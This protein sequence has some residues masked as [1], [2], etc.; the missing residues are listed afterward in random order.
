VVDPNV[1]ASGG[2]A[3]GAGRRR[4]SPLARIVVAFVVIVVALLAAAPS[5]V[6]VVGRAWVES[7]AAAALE[8][9][10][11]IGDLAL[12]WWSGIRVRD[13]DV[14]AREPGK[15]TF[16]IASIEAKPDLG[17]LLSGRVSVP[18]LVVKHV[19][20]ELS[21]DP[22]APE[23]D[24]E[25]DEDEGGDDPASVAKRALPD[26]EVNATIEDVT[27]AYRS[28]E[29]ERPVRISGVGPV[30]ISA[31]SR[32]ATRI[33]VAA[34]P[35]VTAKL[36][37]LW[38]RDGKRLRRRDHTLSGD[39]RLEGADLARFRDAA[40]PWIDA[41]AG[42]AEGAIRVQAVGKGVAST[43]TLRIARAALTPAGA[44]AAHVLEDVTVTH[45]VRRDA[46]TRAWTGT[47]DLASAAGTLA[48]ASA[49][50]QPLVLERAI[51]RGRLS[52]DLRIDVDAVEAVADF[53]RIAGSGSFG[54]GKAPAGTS[55]RL[56][57]T[58]DAQQLA[59][60]L[61]G[62]PPLSGAITSSAAVAIGPD[63]LMTI[64]GA[65]K[66]A[67]FVAQDVPGVGTIRERE[68]VLKHDL[69]WG[70]DAI[71]MHDVGLSS[72]FAT[73][74]CSGAIQTRPGGEA[75]E[76]SL[77]LDVSVALDVVAGLLGEHL[78]MKPSG[79]LAV[80]GK[81]VASPV[82]LAVDVDMK[83]DGITLGGGPFAR[84]PFALGD[85]RAAAKGEIS[86]DWSRLDLPEWSL[87]SSVC[88]LSGSL[89]AS[90]IGDDVHAADVAV[91]GSVEPDR[92]LPALMEEP[93]RARLGPVEVAA[94]VAG[95]DAAWNAAIERVTGAGLTVQGSAVLPRGAARAAPSFSVAILGSVD[96]LAKAFVEGH[97]VSGSIRGNLGGSL[98]DGAVLDAQLQ[99]ENLRVVAAG[100]GGAIGGN[101]LLAG[102]TDEARRFD[103]RLSSPKLTF[104]QKDGRTIAGEVDALLQ[105]RFDPDRDAWVVETLRAT[106]P[107]TS[108]SGHGTF[109]AGE[110][111]DVDVAADLEMAGA[112]PLVAF[113]YPDL[114]CSGKGALAAK[115][116]MSLAEP[117][118]PADSN[119]TLTL[120]M[121]GIRS[122]VFDLRN[123]DVD[124]VMEGGV[125][126]T[127]KATATLNG[128]S[129]QLDLSVDLR[130]AVAEWRGSTKLDAVRITKEMQP[131]I[132][133][134]IPIFAGLAVT[135][136]GTVGATLDLAGRG[137][138]FE[139]AK[140]TLTGSG[141]IRGA[142]TQLSQSKVMAVI[143]QFVG[144]PRDV[145]FE[146]FETRFQVQNGAVRQERLLL[147]SPT[148]DLRMSGTTSFEGRLRYQLG[149]RPK[150]SP[151]EKWRRLERVLD[152]DGFLAMRLEGDVE[153]PDLKPPKVDDLLKSTAEDLLKGKLEDLL[154][155]KKKD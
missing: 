12:G 146:D 88:R 133:R 50:G 60:W 136:T 52:G 92:L 95:S 7:S 93:P 17:A 22:D 98:G 25:D 150:G 87:R 149:V 29:W 152:R 122:E 107:G 63:G 124:A 84:A 14:R 20:L 33:D 142:R 79:T 137:E 102:K 56:E 77:A 129:A 151:S 154:K 49:D 62:L 3:G 144:L 35:G 39:V 46:T 80:T 76:G 27:I 66:V 11:A 83:G 16:R 38:A 155:K 101:V 86:S 28:S 32:D 26:F 36:E 140:R 75:P 100:S 59:A 73:A 43:G 134:A 108:V 116:R 51:L 30:A 2:G 125:A 23:K 126:R 128:G 47:F 9:D 71:K 141:L 143:G 74:R 65:T 55:A 103:A 135:V 67:G 113:L 18:D 145:P 61:G 64:R 115:G 111:A 13:L 24:D 4:R 97:A 121:D 54:A 8:A 114:Q 99:F 15:P 31:S 130:P 5:L 41:L 70:G 44:P 117:R 10:V 138:D 1:A 42:I 34:G 120:R 123:V 119:G 127:R 68:I 139:A 147:S 104:V 91:R 148:M 132:A 106:G 85:V 21:E 81:V 45:D 153:D 78:A 19:T 82:G 118:R 94:K 112:A 131:A 90:G 89:Q 40:G 109:A 58:A 110:F 37:V 72:S 105:G 48:P 96:Q 6:G 57:V 69:D 53:G